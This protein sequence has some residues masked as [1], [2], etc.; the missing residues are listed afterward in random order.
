MPT[1]SSNHAR[2]IKYKDWSPTQMDKAV[3]AVV[4]EGLSIRCAALQYGVPKSSL[5][6]RISGRVKPGALSGPPKYLSTE[7]ENELVRHLS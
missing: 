6:D 7:E 1:T 4:S 3:S 2:A 5:G